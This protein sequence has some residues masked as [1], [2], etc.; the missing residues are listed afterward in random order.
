MASTT[1]PPTSTNENEN[2][3]NSSMPFPPTE[4]DATTSPP[5]EPPP[6][7]PPSLPFFAL[8]SSL[9]FA[10]NPTPPTTHHP[11]V[12]YIFAD[13][14]I[15]FLHHI[16]APPSSEPA[17]PS[18]EPQERVLLLDINADCTRIRRAVSLSPDWQVTA[19]ALERAPAWRPSGEGGRVEGAGQL[20]AGTE[21]GGWM[22]RVEGVEAGEGVV[23]GGMLELAEVFKARLDALRAVVE[24]GRVVGG[25]EG[26]E[27]ADAVA[28]GE[29]LEGEGEGEGEGDTAAA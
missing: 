3:P 4:P 14:D 7:A 8:V 23:E 2:N 15:D 13:D 11:T 12:R 22:L 1:P 19:A 20:E 6:T 10:P 18:D 25:E 21:A 26:A 9:P 29:E 24:N 16:S 27:Q 28:R 17:S 5:N